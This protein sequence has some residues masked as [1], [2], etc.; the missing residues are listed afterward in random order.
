MRDLG[1]AGPELTC[2]EQASGE[3][4]GVGRVLQREG[5]RV[6]CMCCVCAV[7]VLCCAHGAQEALSAWNSK[8]EALSFLSESHPLIFSLDN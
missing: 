4:E 8:L 1:Q 7:R 6:L 5:R 3:A 2:A